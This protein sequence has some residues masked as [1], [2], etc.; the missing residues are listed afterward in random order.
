MDIRSWKVPY[1]PVLFD[2]SK[3]RGST[4]SLQGS[5]SAACFFPIILS[6]NPFASRH[7]GDEFRGDGTTDERQHGDAGNGQPNGNEWICRVAS[8]KDR[9]DVAQEE[10]MHQ[11]HAE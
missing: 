8:H 2:K 11:V 5:L 1:E 10:E 9:S 7:V 3:A 4:T 6:N